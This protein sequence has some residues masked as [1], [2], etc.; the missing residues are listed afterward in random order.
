MFFIPEGTD[1]FVQFLLEEIAPMLVQFPWNAIW[2]TAFPFFD[3]L[4]G[5]NYFLKFWRPV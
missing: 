2:A 1:N 3:A 5:I 4:D